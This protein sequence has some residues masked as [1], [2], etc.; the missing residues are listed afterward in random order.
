M[1]LKNKRLS[2]ARDK[3]AQ[4]LD[5]RKV[6]PNDNGIPQSSTNPLAARK[7]ATPLDV[8]GETRKRNEKCCQLIHV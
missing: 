5:W 4:V 3:K 1:K 2:Y 7:K 8:V 6:V